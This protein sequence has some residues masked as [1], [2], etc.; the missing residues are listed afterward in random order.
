VSYLNVF[1]TD[2]SP[3]KPR[4][5]RNQSLSPY[6]LPKSIR[7]GDTQFLIFTFSFSMRG[8]FWGGI[9]RGN[10]YGT[11]EDERWKKRIKEEV[12]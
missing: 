2:L 12:K 3:L 1:S 6:I 8:S 10:E 9:A 5:E 11:T 4:G 7:K